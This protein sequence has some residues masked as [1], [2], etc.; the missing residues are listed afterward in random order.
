MLPAAARRP[1]TAR[2]LNQSHPYQHRTASHPDRRGGAEPNGTARV[3]RAEIR[4]DARKFAPLARKSQTDSRASPWARHADAA[5]LRQ[6]ARQDIRPGKQ[7]CVP[8]RAVAEWLRCAL[9]MRS[10]HQCSTGRVAASRPRGCCTRTVLRSHTFRPGHCAHLA[11]RETK[12]VP[13]SNKAPY[14]STNPR[15]SWHEAWSC[16]DPAADMP[17]LMHG[18]D[19]IRGAAAPP[20]PL[21]PPTPNPRGHRFHPLIRNRKG[22]DTKCRGPSRAVAGRRGRPNLRLDGRCAAHGLTRSRGRSEPDPA[23]PPAVPPVVPP[24]E[25]TLIERQSGV[26]INNAARRR[27]VS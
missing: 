25:P 16:F 6:C 13:A 20:Q 21:P 1:R 11:H 7:K 27:G 4:R 17:F 23:V 5:S 14:L 26:R 2:P 12:P 18:S 10:V 24:A 9:R 22:D 19:L 15:N 8:F 3:S